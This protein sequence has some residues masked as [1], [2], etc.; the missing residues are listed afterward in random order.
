MCEGDGPTPKKAS[1]KTM[2]GSVA[3][4]A[5]SWTFIQLTGQAYRLTLCKSHVYTTYLH[6]YLLHVIRVNVAKLGYR[7]RRDGVWWRVN[8][9]GAG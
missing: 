9:F 1:L 3:V 8:G 7:A 6:A 2:G 4:Q 5:Y